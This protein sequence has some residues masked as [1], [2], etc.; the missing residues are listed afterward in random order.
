MAMPLRMKRMV[1][2]R[3]NLEKPNEDYAVFFGDNNL[4]SFYAYVMGPA[5]TLYEHKF[6]K[7][8]FDIPESYPL[9]CIIVTKSE[10]PA[11]LLELI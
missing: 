3:Q 7:L 1:R 10:S 8:K 6:V 4:F 5:D 2:E 11:L 9:V